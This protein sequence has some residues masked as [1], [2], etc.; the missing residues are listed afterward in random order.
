MRQEIKVKLFYIKEKVYLWMN[1]IH[2]KKSSKK[3]NNKSIESF[4]IVKNIKKI[5]YELDLFK[6][7]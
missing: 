5:S 7:M 2:M 3:L 6:K 1:N 4:K